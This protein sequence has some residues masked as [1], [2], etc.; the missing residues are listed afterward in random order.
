MGQFIEDL[1]YKIKASSS[2][3]FL[4]TFKFIIGF[5]LGLTFAL[6]GQEI[7]AYQ[8]FSFMLVILTT[9]T[10]FYRI[11]RGWKFGATLAF[12]LVCVLIG[13]LLK[14]YILVAPGA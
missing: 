4:V 8:S 1:Q 6:I 3:L 9:I 2:N 12:T 11:A 10:V 7:W 5:F 14:M 13:L